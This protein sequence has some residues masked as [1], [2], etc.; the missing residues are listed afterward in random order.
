MSNELSTD[1][2]PKILF[3]TP[4][5]RRRTKGNALA[6]SRPRIAFH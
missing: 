3:A 4:S 2:H 5:K 1:F 6:L